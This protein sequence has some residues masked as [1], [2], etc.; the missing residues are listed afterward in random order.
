[1]K[2]S[3]FVVE[4][5]HDSAAVCKILKLNG[6][7]SIDKKEEVPACFQELIPVSF[8]FS[9]DSLDRV[10][11]IPHFVKKGNERCA[12]ICVAAGDSR[13]ADKLSVSL[14]NIDISNLEQVMA[15]GILLDADKQEVAVRKEKLLQELTRVCVENDWELEEDGIALYMQKI[16]YLIYAFPDDEQEGT[17][18]DVLLP[19]QNWEYRDLQCLAE[20]FV[21]QVPSNYQSRWKHADNKKVKVGVISNVLRP[22]KANQISI[23]DCSWFT[24]ESIDQISIH[25]KF[26]DF[27]LHVACWERG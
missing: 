2:T 7:K 25:K 21:E 3:L 8:P 20:Q 26:A 6:Y 5:P 24:K 19:E 11:P 9:G 12:A 13:I 18:E 15:V 10:A 17:L 22:G 16:P 14:K 27:V 4:G 23:L 1:M